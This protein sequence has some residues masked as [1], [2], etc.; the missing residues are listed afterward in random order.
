MVA[1]LCSVVLLIPRLQ[2]GIVKGSKYSRTIPRSQ[3]RRKKTQP[4]Q[5]DEQY[6]ICRYTQVVDQNN[7]EVRL[8]DVRRGKY[9]TVSSQL[10]SAHTETKNHIPSLRL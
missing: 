7:K 6:D 2:Q 4:Q 8:D 3:S 5:V 10:G 9:S 1:I